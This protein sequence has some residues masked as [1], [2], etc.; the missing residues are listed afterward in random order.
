MLY[1]DIPALSDLRKLNEVRADA[2]VSDKSDD[3]MD[4][5]GMAMNYAKEAK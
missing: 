3:R 2:C 5:I 1:V 4:A